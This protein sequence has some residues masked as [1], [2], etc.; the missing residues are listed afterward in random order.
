MNTA[1]LSLTENLIVEGVVE[2]SDPIKSSDKHVGTAVF[3]SKCLEFFKFYLR[4]LW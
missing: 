2:V 1:L 4:T 3:G